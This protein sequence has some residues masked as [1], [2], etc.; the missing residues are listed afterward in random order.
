MSFLEKEEEIMNLG[1]LT[2]SSVT[3]DLACSAF[4]CLNELYEGRGEFSRYNGKARLAGIIN[5]AGCST[6]V[7]PEKLLKRIR[8]LTELK[9]DAIH[10]STCMINLCPFKNKYYKMLTEN[11]P[12]IQFVKGTHGGPV[13]MSEAEHKKIHRNMV[14]DLVIQ[15]NT[16]ADMITVLYNR[17]DF[18]VEE[19]LLKS[20]RNSNRK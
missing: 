17:S 16:M 6:L 20:V 14:K 4:N 19:K 18:S 2:C 3:Q 10:L 8:S 12:Q 7:A 15:G 13:E 11:F 5:C 9:P 1:I